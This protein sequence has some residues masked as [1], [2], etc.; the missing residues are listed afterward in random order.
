M[1]ATAPARQLLMYNGVMAAS[2]KAER[3][4]KLKKQLLDL[5]RVYAADIK[6]SHHEPGQTLQ[7]IQLYE[8]QIK[9]LEQSPE[10]DTGRS[11]KLES[12]DGEV[13][14]FI[15]VENNPDPSVGR[16]SK[17][18]EVGAK[19]TDLKPGSGIQIGDKMFSLKA[20]S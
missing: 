16:I 6:A 11:F 7:M 12:A 4:K 1:T 2:E 17:D 5:R 20:V 8:K 13:K 3:L 9:E 18:S 15:V 10:D 14:T 19:L